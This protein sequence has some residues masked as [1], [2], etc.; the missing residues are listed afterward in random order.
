LQQWQEEEP[1]SSGGQCVHT[2]AKLPP[3]RAAWPHRWNLAGRMS[4]REEEAAS[5]QLLLTGC[6]NGATC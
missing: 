6:S 5:R 4:Q 2:T 3:G 1:T